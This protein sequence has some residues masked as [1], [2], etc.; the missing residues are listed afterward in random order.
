MIVKFFKKLFNATVVP[1][2][3]TLE[4]ASGELI[5]NVDESE[6]GELSIL[7]YYY[8]NMRFGMNMSDF[9]GEIAYGIWVGQM[10]YILKLIKEK[11]YIVKEDDDFPYEATM[12]SSYLEYLRR[13][14]ASSE[15]S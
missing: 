7:N 2:V 12:E 3:A 11:K 8:D 15:R 5:G 14:K 4:Y 1:V 9:P 13:K 6:R 10:R